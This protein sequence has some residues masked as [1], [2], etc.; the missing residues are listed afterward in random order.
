MGLGF[1]G[2]PRPAL[3]AE[4]PA[5]AEEA[6]L[7]GDEEGEQHDGRQEGNDIQ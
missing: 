7:E 3:L 6:A 1:G 4:A 2:L 5:A